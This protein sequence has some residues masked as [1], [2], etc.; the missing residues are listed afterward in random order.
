MAFEASTYRIPL[1]DILPLREVPPKVLESVKYGQIAASIAEVGI[2]E[3]PVVA[4]DAVDPNRYH[5]LDGHLRIAVLRQ[6]GETEVVCLIATEDE[7]F[8]YNRRVSRIAIIQEHKMILNAVKKGVS[9]QRLARALNVDIEHIR[10][11][12]NLLAGICPEAADLLR[13]KHLPMGAFVELRR[14]K[15]MRQIV[16]AEMMI[17]LNR[18]STSHAKAIV[19]GT[20]EEDLVEGRAKAVR[21][22]TEEQLSLMERE[23]AALDRDFKL[24]EQSYGADHLD[25]VLAVGY[26][27]RLLG[28]V[29]VVRHLA[30]HHA[31][32]LS[33]FQKITELQ[34]A[35]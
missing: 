29:R 19:A 16:A 10:K 4:R 32:L 35:A 8:T 20:A 1:S 2:I 23:S 26:V 9:E 3:P 17:A 34:K 12:R 22:L 5:L 14:L 13:D 7:A 31:D 28:N 27:Q 33:E 24:I 25:L 6:R 15:P 21:G 18:Y 30:Q 11:K